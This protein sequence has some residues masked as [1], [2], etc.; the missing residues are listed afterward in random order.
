[1]ETVNIE[2][3]EQEMGAIDSLIQQSGWQVLL[4]HAARFTNDKQR[5]FS[6]RTA[7]G[8]LKERGAEQYALTMV[9][10]VEYCRGVSDIVMLPQHLRRQHRLARAQRPKEKKSNG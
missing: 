10:I 8:K 2:E 9:G 1:M 7:H 6:N 3:L 4:K 5:T